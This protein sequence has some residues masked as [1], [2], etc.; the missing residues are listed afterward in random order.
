MI[1]FCGCSSLGLT[2]YPTG[3]FLTDQSE[4][5][6]ASSLREANL[7]KELSKGVLPVHYLEPGDVLLI[8]PVDFESQI[9]I[10]ADQHVLADGSIDLGGF[11]R[12]VV[13]G[14]TL[15]AAEGLIEQTIVHS[16]E[17]ETQINIRLLESVHR[18][19]VLGEVNSPGS[20][21]LE[22][23][24]TVL[25]AIL[26]AGGLTSDAS[27]CKLL[28][29]RPTMERSCRVTLPI[30]YREITQLGD[31]STNYQIQ[32]GDRIFVSSRSFCEEL[33]CCLVNE[34]CER[35]CK[36]QSPCGDPALLHRGNPYPRVAAERAT[37]MWKTPRDAGATKTPTIMRNS[38]A[39][40]QPEDVLP[41]PL[42]DSALSDATNTNNADPD[43]P[44]LP[45]RRLP[46]VEK[47]DLDP[48]AELGINAVD[49]AKAE[50]MN[51]VEVGSETLGDILDGQ[52]PSNLQAPVIPDSFG[53]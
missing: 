22:G 50:A 10:P 12:A 31:S 20:Y 2:L 4:Q 5:V 19:Y 53:D 41:N 46:T 8:E 33:K 45:I 28:L 32:P 27:P 7:P 18:F 35:C 16:G 36:C 26:T 39:N 40:T 43:A 30:C 42:S 34:T 17:E 9:R 47:S 15:E 25:D 29:A 13:A 49:A 51:T 52:L 48:P 21:P 38:Q 1:S 3:H 24:E 6:L 37:A 11:G 44:A 23:N 14:L